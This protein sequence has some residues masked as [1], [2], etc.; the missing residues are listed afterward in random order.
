MRSIRPFFRKNIYMQCLPD[1]QHVEEKNDDYFKK[2]LYNNVGGIIFQ[3]CSV[4]WVRKISET[5]CEPGYKD[6]NI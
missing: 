5:R 1:S 3:I 4:G 6:K 2:S